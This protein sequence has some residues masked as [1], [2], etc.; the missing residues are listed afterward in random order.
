M[1]LAKT[2]LTDLTIEEI[3]KIENYALMWQIN[4]KKWLDEWTA[5]P[6]GLGEKMLEK[7][8]AEL[9]E[10]DDT[11]IKLVAPLQKFRVKLRDFTSLKRRRLSITCSLT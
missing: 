7:D 8:A 4:G 9:R 2:G 11:R 3:A 1:R 5:H 10:I 6:N